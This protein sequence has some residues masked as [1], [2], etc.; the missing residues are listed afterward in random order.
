MC[1]ELKILSD[2]EDYYDN[3]S[4]NNGTIIYNRNFG[5]SLSKAGALKYIRSLGIPTIETQAVKEIAPGVKRIVVYMDPKA[6]EGK[7]KQVMKRS[8]ALSYY[9][10]YLASPYIEST[11]G[12]YIK[13]LQIGTRRFKLLLQHTNDGDLTTGRVLDIQELEPQLSSI[14]YPIFSI[15]YIPYNGMS[16]ATDFNQVQKLVGLGIESILKPEDVVLEIEKTLKIFK[17]LGD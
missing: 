6:H 1:T 2:F 4:N 16:V 13:M 15:D 3:Q 14:V 17:G 7:G 12:L 9:G 8:D 11:N 5:E 10:N